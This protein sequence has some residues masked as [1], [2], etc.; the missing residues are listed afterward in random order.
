MSK[1]T[2]KF[3]LVL[4][5]VGCALFLLASPFGDW[6]GK[7]FSAP[8]SKE[9][10][11]VA[12]KRTAALPTLKI[13]RDAFK[14]GKKGALDTQDTDF[15]ERKLETTSSTLQNE[16]IDQVMLRHQNLFQRCWTQRLKETP[17]L[18]GHVL[19]Q[20]EIT[21]RGKTQNAK[22]AET[23]IKDETMLQCLA[24]VVDRIT[25]HEFKGSPIVLTFPLSFE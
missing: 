22:V 5:A 21:T 15:L 11:P 13:R 14:P 20:F 16:E 3:A 23:D 4:I 9:S 8:E 18:S 12:T 24:S 10:P 6:L 1:D 25:F 7:K 19:L 17:S 2:T